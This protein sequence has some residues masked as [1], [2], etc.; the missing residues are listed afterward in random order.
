MRRLRLRH[1]TSPQK[2]SQCGAP[3]LATDRGGGWWH[4]LRPRPALRR[5]TLRR[6]ALRRPA[7]RHPTS[8]LPTPTPLSPATGIAPAYVVPAWCAA[9]VQAQ[10]AETRAADRAVRF[11]RQTRQRPT[12]AAP[13]ATEEDDSEYFSTYLWLFRTRMPI[14]CRQ[15]LL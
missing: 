1:T 5:P 15:N 9:L 11:P 8:L 7:L 3:S 13:S 10:Y 14:L 6:P 2:T 4:S 12:S